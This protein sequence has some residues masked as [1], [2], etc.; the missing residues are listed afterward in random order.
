M[1]VQI[2]GQRAPTRESGL[3]ALYDV[4][5]VVPGCSP[6]ASTARRRDHQ[7]KHWHLQEDVATIA[8]STTTR[9]TVGKL[10]SGEVAPLETLAM[11]AIV[12]KIAPVPPAAMAIVEPPLEKPESQPA[13]YATASRPV[14]KV[15]PSSKAAQS[16]LLSCC[17]RC[18]EEGERDAQESMKAMNGLPAR[19]R[20]SR[21]HAKERA[22]NGRHHRE[23]EQH[24][25]VAQHAVCALRTEPP[26]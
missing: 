1:N 2:H 17:A 13:G 9:P 21:L 3:A 4:A 11:P 22:G 19:N 16:P 18:P 6:R 24:V 26:C 25:G 5:D 12:A 10:P 7:V 15:K 14:K 20:S 23:C 8:S